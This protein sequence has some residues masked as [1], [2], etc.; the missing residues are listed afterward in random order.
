MCQAL[1]LNNM[2]RIGTHLFWSEC[3]DR[4]QYCYNTL[5][6]C[7]LEIWFI[8]IKCS[9]VARRNVHVIYCFRLRLTNLL[10]RF[11]SAHI[12]LLG[13]CLMWCHLQMK[14]ALYFW[15]LIIAMRLRRC[16]NMNWKKIYQISSNESKS[17]ATDCHMTIAIGIRF[18]STTMIS[19]D[20]F[21]GN[22]SKRCCD[23]V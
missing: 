17:E 22:E 9:I 11:V 3:S 5:K 18:E 6:F 20:C 2:L 8:Q 15:Q 13:L 4:H 23:R 16:R 12:N 1:G 14:F 7:C 10:D 19:A 21:I